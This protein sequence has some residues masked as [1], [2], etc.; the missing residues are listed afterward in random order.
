M[1]YGADQHSQCQRQ[2]GVRP[3]PPKV[4]R[5][6]SRP[7]HLHT[8]AVTS[9]AATVSDEHPALLLLVAFPSRALTLPLLTPLGPELPSPSR[10][11]NADG[12][13]AGGKIMPTI[14]VISRQLD[15]RANPGCGDRQPRT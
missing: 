7:D 11:V 3:R 1:T 2:G 15:R 9:L 13:P 12:P 5:H 8:P 6:G 4:L 10:L 14:R